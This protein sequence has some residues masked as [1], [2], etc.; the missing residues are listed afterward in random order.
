MLG[1]SFAFSCMNACAKLASATLPPTEVAFARAFVNLLFLA[2][3][4]AWHGISFLGTRR[5]LLLTRS[6]SGATSLIFNFSAAARLPLADLGALLKTGVLFTVILG[7]LVLKEKFSA[8]RASY[9]LL[10]FAGAL[11][12][13][14]PTFEVDSI[15][16]FEALASAFFGSISAISIRELGGTERPA[17]VVFQFCAYASLILFVLFGVHFEM[18]Q[19]RE[20]LLLIGAG[21]AGTLGQVAVTSALQRAPASLVAPYSFS[22]VLFAATIGVVFL[23]ESLSPTSALGALIIVGA[24]V[25]LGRSAIRHG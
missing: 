20:W 9:V 18:P 1:A 13:L 16:G 5:R 14:K 24:G 3:W 2:P 11:V 19:G 10:G 21:L 4:M 23:G 17:T 7:T 22:E 6:L 25:L 8:R 15:G 12:V